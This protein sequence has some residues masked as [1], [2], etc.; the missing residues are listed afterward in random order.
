MNKLRKPSLSRKLEGITKCSAVRPWLL[1]LIMIGCGIFFVFAGF[2]YG[3]IM[4]GVPYPDPTP[5]QLTQQTRDIKISG[6]L[7]I[8]GFIFTLVGL[9]ILVTT[10]LIRLVRAQIKKT[11]A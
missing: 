1:P 9:L 6:W 5:E 4:V 7:M 3:A 8:L 2:F 10:V 11:E